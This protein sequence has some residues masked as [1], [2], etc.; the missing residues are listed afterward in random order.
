[1]IGVRETDRE[2]YDAIAEAGTPKVDKALRTL[3]HAANY[4]RLWMG[5]AAAMAVFGGPTGRRAAVTGMVAV[6]LTSGVVNQGF[7]RMF[8]RDRPTRLEENLNRHV[9]MPESTSFPSG[10]SASAFAFAQAV[11]QTMPWMGLALRG[12]A[13]LV[14]YSRVHTGVHYPLDVAAGAMIG[15]GIGQLTAEG[16]DK[17]WR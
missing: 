3:S 5:T 8:H 15:M 10:H 4:S 16:V 1:M 17:V 2:L 9:R 11:S 7:K 13:A 6:G 14:A 12:T